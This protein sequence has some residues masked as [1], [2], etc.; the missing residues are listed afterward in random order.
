MCRLFLTEVKLFLSY[1]SPP[2]AA[3]KLNQKDL[4]T[5]KGQHDLF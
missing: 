2:S 3:M 4:K 5:K 1:M